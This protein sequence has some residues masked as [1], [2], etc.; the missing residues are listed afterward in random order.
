MERG[1][2]L[3]NPYDAGMPDKAKTMSDSARVEASPEA[4]MA[5]WFHPDR[6][7]EFRDRLERSGASDVSVSDTRYGDIA[8]LNA[9]YRNRRGKSVHQRKERRLTPEAMAPLSGDRFVAES[10][11]ILVKETQSGRQIT[12]TCA[13]R[14]E[15]IPQSDGSTQVVSVHQHALT[16]GTWAERLGNRRGDAALQSRQFAELIDG[17]RAAMSS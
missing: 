5:W 3:S 9:A 17:C 12:R 13:G 1:K 15:F 14:I 4:I 2:P 16:G 7:Q 11:D 8:V 10:T 6:S